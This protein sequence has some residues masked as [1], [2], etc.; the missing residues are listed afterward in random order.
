VWQSAVQAAEVNAAAYLE[1]ANEVARTHHAT[2][3]S[4]RDRDTLLSLLDADAAP[5]ARLTRA[6]ARYRK[7]KKSSGTSR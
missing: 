2:I 3:L 7:F 1:R 4:D 5:N 6:A